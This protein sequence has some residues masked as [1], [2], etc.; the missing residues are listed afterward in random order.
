MEQFRTLMTRF[1]RPGRLEWIGVRGERRGAV[2]AV[3][4]VLARAGLGLAGDHYRAGVKGSR[5]SRS[6]RPS[7]CR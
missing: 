1:P 5:K 6:S 2:S 3:Q 7:T 4:E